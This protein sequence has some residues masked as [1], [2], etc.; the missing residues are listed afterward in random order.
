MKVSTYT[1]NCEYCNSEFTTNLYKKR[2][3]SYACVLK[4][5]FIIN[6]NKRKEKGYVH[7]PPKLTVRICLYCKN[8]FTIKH[9]S[10]G[11]ERKFCSRKCSAKGGASII[12]EK[13]KLNWQKE[14]ELG[15]KRTPARPKR[16]LNIECSYCKNKFTVA[17][18]YR[19]RKFCSNK[20]YHESKKF[21]RIVKCEYCGKDFV[22]KSYKQ[23]YCSMSCSSK[24]IGEKQRG[25]NAPFYGRHHTETTLKILSK[26][27]KEYIAKNGNAF[28]DCKH[29][30]AARQV[31][32]DKSV[33]RIIDNNG[34]HPCV[35][36][37]KQGLFYSN[38]N[39][40][41]IAFDSSYEEKFYSLLENNISVLSYGRSN[42]KLKY[43]F[44]NII[45]T[46]NPDLLVYYS[47]GRMELV[48]IKPDRR[49]LEPEIIAKHTAAEDYC[50]QNKLIFK[51][52]TEE[53]IF[54]RED[55]EWG[56]LRQE[57]KNKLPP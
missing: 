23:K 25:E 52:I 42:I 33:Q 22:E 46:Y 24:A 29:T 39:S 45:K 20:C 18:K 7:F 37:Y 2:Y 4:Q 8:E 53:H 10:K 9:I 38:K 41:K 13:Q 47:D 35:K 26:K 50:K 5:R 31:M 51:I 21:D 12:S 16:I 1:Y 19:K 14:K 54:T 34:K 56:F 40:K 44:N 32:S 3:C 49:L 27:S 30:A 17:Y 55:R 57:T 11:K 48:E 6:E 43:L 28:Q 36:G 15:I